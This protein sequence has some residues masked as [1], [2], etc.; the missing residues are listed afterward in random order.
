MKQTFNL[1]GHFNLPLLMDGDNACSEGSVLT[2]VRSPF[3]Q[4]DSGTTPACDAA[5]RV[6]DFRS[7]GFELTLLCHILSIPVCYPK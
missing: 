2:R 6:H 4:L 7:Y 5:A 1:P 3:L